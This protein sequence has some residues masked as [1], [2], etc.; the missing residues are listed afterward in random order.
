MVKAAQ[1]KLIS[2][3]AEP[4]YPWL[5][6]IWSSFT[7]QVDERRLP[8]A[9]LLVGPDGVGC[10]DLSLSMA[11]YLLC[12]APQNG[13]SCGQCKSCHLTR[14]DGH[15]DLHLLTL[16]VNEKT[17]KQAQSIRI[18]QVREVSESIANTA[19][20]GGRKLIVIHPAESMNIN[21]ANALLKSLEEPN[22]D[23]VF[24]L[25]SEQPAFLAAT[26]RSRCTRVV[27]GLPSQDESLAW[28]ER[29]QISDAQKRLI[30]VGGRPLR[31]I[32][33]LE[34]DLW[35]QKDELRAH[36]QALLEGRQS[37][38]ECAKSIA[39]GGP[40]W[41]LEQMQ[42]WL[43]AAIPCSLGAVASVDTTDP[44]VQILQRQPSN[45]LF[46]LHDVVV[47]KKKLILSSANPNPQLVIEEVLMQI[48]EF[49][50]VGR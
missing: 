16:E 7:K 44:L 35:G 9:I 2:L 17:K 1:P 19:Q 28:L 26:I 8:H 37:F 49:A 10:V 48:Q 13:Q 21:S 12:V 32:E 43:A 45:R 24:I 39:G 23:C 14:V 38:L 22:G 30:E 33:W 41:L 29:N 47:S 46:K 18:Q 42:H 50:Q 40:L 31:V 6:Q 5:S 34:K 27:V 25:V 15:P 3:R 4:P 11:Q 20:Q 36:L